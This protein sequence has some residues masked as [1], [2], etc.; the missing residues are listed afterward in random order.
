MDEVKYYTVA[1]SLF[2]F[3]EMRSVSTTKQSDSLP[4]E[5]PQDYFDLDRRDIDN[6][7]FCSCYAQDLFTFYKKQ[8]AQH[9]VDSTYMTKQKSLITTHIRANIVSTMVL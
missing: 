9:R 3:V 1:C 8:E 7:R 6:P 4:V 5:K 2:A